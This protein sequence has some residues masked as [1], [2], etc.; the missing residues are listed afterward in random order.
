MKLSRLQPRIKATST[1]RLQELVAK[2]GIVERKRGSAGMK[3]RDSIKR[4]DCGLC[5]ACKAKGIVR[6]GGLVDHIKPL[7]EGGSDEDTNKQLLC[8]PC[9]DAKT[10]DE[11]LRRTRGY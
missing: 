11:A 10:A 2:P 5:Q 8:K 6:P 4:R 3:D 9:H 1:T 7:W